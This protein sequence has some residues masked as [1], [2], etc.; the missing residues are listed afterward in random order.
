MSNIKVESH[1][2]QK[3]LSRHTG[4]KTHTHTHTRQTNCSPDHQS[5]RESLVHYVRN[6]S[7]EQ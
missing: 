2:V 6:K 3:L 7:V 1:L 4:T 5:V